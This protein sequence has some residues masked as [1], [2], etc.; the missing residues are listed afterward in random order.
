MP[1]LKNKDTTLLEHLIEKKTNIY[2]VTETW[3]EQ[4]DAIWLECSDISRNGYTFLTHN[5][6]VR[7]G[8]GLV[9][10][11]RSNLQV[12]A[13]KANYN[14]SME[15]A[16][17]KVNTGTVTINIFAINHPPYSDISTNAM[18]LDD[19]ADI[20]EKHLMPL[21]NIMVTGDFNLHI[22]KMN[23]PYEPLFKDIVQAFDLDC[24]VDFPTHWSGHALDL[25][26]TG[27]IGNIK[28][29][30]CEPGVLLS[31]HCSV[32]LILNIKKT[33]LE[34]KEQSYRKID[35]INVEVFCNELHVNQQEVLPLKDKIKQLNSE[36]T[37]ILNKLAP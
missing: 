34:R 24:K 32:E 3:L 16:V 25:I 4:N 12:S 14:R 5:R 23:D 17:W 18:F 1:S 29:S 33:K 19:L 7:T 31:D 27:V 11:Y 26:L 15:Y 35:A 10:V 8:G 36:L 28:M 13:I 37:R 21:S 20:F 6:N 2:T 30:N 9:I 22:D